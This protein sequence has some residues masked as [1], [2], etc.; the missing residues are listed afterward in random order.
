[1]ALAKDAGIAVGRGIVVDDHLQTVRR[2]SLRSA[3]AP[4]IAASATASSSRL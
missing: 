2:K 3:N 1:V 4:S